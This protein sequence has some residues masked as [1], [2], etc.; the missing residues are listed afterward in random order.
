MELISGT[1]DGTNPP[2]APAY[3]QLSLEGILAPFAALH[4]R[5]RAEIAPAEFGG[6]PLWGFVSV[7]NN[8][9]QQVTTI[10]P[11]IVPTAVAIPTPPTLTVGHWGSPESCVDVTATQVTATFNCQGGSFPFPLVGPDG[12]FEVDGTFQALSPLPL[13]PVPAHYSG[14]LQGQTLTLTV[15]AG[16]VTI[17]GISVQFGFAGDCSTEACPISDDP[18]RKSP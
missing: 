17:Q 2:V 6:T 9:T 14:V 16:T 4:A 18:L 8:I 3:G 13:M 1:Q 7:T 11:A 5:V 12:R 10:T 15:H